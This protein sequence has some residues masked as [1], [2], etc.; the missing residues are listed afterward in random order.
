MAISK[1]LDILLRLTAHLEGITPANGYEFDMT[2]R[3]FR[4][5]VF[6]GDDDPLPMIAILELL[7]ADADLQMAG[8]HDSDHTEDWVLLVQGF[9]EGTPENPTDLAYQFKAAVEQRLSDCIATNRDGNPAVPEAYMLGLWKKGVESISIGPGL[10]SP[11]RETISAYSFF[12]LPIGIGRT[13][14][15]TKPFV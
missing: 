4:G 3:V 7:Q 6:Y 5:R 1:Q 10:V 13:V 14:E 11:P 9:I 2:A 15:L 12:Y 8:L